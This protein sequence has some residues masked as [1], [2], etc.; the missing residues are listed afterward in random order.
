[1]A[2]IASLAE[3]TYT[4]EIEEMGRSLYRIAVDGKEFLVDCRKTGVTNFSLIVDNRSFE[5]DVDTSEDEY[6]VLV[7][8][9][10]YHIQLVDERRRRLGGLQSGVQIQGRQ[11]ISVPMPGRIIAVLVR[12]G[13]PVK[14]GE[15]LA[16]VEA[17]KMENEVR[18]PL[19]GEVKEVRVKA[20]DVVEAGVILAVVE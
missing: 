3:R 17:M 4:L 7:D 2:F 11:E 8:G 10:S 9:R 20:G 14:K 15:G 13:D 1:M 12:E 6:R 19:A 16:I 18:S 5:V